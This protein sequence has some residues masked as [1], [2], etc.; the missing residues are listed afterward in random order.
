V[1]NWHR[2]VDGA[3][4][5]ESEPDGPL[6]IRDTRLGQP[7]RRF[8]LSGLERELYELCR[9]VR[10]RAALLAHVHAYV[11]ARRTSRPAVDAIE[12][13]LDTFLAAMTAN[14]LMLREGDQYLSLAIDPA[15]DRGA[16][17]AALAAALA[18]VS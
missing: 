13:A 16:L 6:T 18:A 1:E 5:V 7:E 15:L 17:E 14:R 11:L 2:H 12:T 9:D 4:T 8:L 3:L 10:S